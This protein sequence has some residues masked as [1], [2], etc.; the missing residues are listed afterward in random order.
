MAND[1]AQLDM[2]PAGMHLLRLD[3]GRHTGQ[4]YK[5]TVQLDLFGGA[6]LIRV[7]GRIGSRGRQCID[8]HPDEG[9]ASN[10]L[11]ALARKKRLLGYEP[12]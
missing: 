6:S 1:T 4:F 5:M 2:F 12:Q 11:M 7:W 3:T 10:A 9:Q 8:R